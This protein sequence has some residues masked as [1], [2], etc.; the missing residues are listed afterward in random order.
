VVDGLGRVV[1][2][3]LFA[4]EL[5]EQG[6]PR[7]LEPGVL[8]DFVQ[9]QIPETLPAVASSPEATAWL[10]AH[11]LTPFLD[12]VR[13]ERLAEVE[14]IATHVELSLTEILQKADEEIG[15]AAV[16][17]EQHVTGAEGRLAQ[18]EARH[19]ELLAR[20]EQR[21]QELE[22]QRALTLQAVERLTSVLVLPHPEREA[23]EVRRLQP[24]AETEVIAM[25]M[26]MEYEVEQGRQ[27]YDV[28]DKN[29]GYD[30]T[31][32]DLRSGEL[33]LIE[34]K[35]IGAA[36]GTVLLTPNERRVAEDRRDCYWLYVVTHCQ[37]TPQV[38]EPIKDPAR[39]PWHEVRKVEHYWL[40]VDALTQ[41]MQVREDE[42]AYGGQS[43]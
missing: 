8:G 10:T 29:L 22:R 36:T 18:A 14:R 30:L 42:S 17:V 9:A 31:S 43:L 25:R 40:E 16:D 11:I 1:H 6:G 28:H 15:K 24:N 5:T 38:Q 37:S 7:A 35:G 27:V 39:F 21:R 4:V 26:V 34:V 20:R 32:L 23:P 2:E 12:E 33:R 41:S 13:G 19:A 3:H